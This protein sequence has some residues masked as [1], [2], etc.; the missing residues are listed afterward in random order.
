ME[1]QIT[2]PTVYGIVIIESHVK[3]LQFFLKYMQVSL[4]KKISIEWSPAKIKKEIWITMPPPTLCSLL[5]Q[6]S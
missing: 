1:W 6:S 3:K 2:K 5:S 4:S